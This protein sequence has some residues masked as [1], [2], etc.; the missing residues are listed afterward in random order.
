MKNFQEIKFGISTLDR[1]H[2]RNAIYQFVVKHF[3]QFSGKLID[4][5]CGKMPYRD[6]VIKNAQLDSYDG[7]DL[8]GHFVYDDK[9]KPDFYWDGKELPMNE[10]SYQTAFLFEVLEHCP[11]PKIVIKE[12]HRVLDSNGKLFFTVPNI[13]PLHEA[14]YD[15][16]RYTPYSLKLLMKEVGFSKVEIFHGG[17]WNA[18]LGQTLGLYLR[19]KPMNKYL[20]HIISIVCAP[21]IFLLYKFDR[22]PQNSG[23]QQLAP[24]YQGVATK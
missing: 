21:I 22:V 15:M 18:S 16:Y 2:I 13:W 19:R 24:S 12:A 17:G 6:L 5:G 9:I 3:D 1:F 8:E 4:I 10:N 20:R 23:N 7:V 11:D 14:P